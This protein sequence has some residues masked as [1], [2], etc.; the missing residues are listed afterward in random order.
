[1]SEPRSSGHA[2]IQQRWPRGAESQR[3][4]IRDAA[5]A[6]R[7]LVAEALRALDAGNPHIVRAALGLIAA[8]LSDIQLLAVEAK[9]GPDPEP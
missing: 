5:K 7:D 6:G 3:L 1:M 9:V 4:Q 2:K 8:Q